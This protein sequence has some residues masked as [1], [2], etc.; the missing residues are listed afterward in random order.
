M[1]PTEL[2]SLAE[3]SPGVILIA[4]GLYAFKV[5]ANDLK[6]DVEA[7]RKNTD[8][9]VKEAARQTE[10]LGRIERI[11]SAENPMVS[12]ARNAVRRPRGEQE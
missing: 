2:V 5:L 7:S 3:K 1:F 10:L 11:L 9:L 8:D 6:H 12:R 4:I